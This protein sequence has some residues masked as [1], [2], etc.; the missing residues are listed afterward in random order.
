MHRQGGHTRHCKRHNKGFKLFK[1]LKPFGGKYMS[2]ELKPG[3]LN[4][5]GNGAQVKKNTNT[6]KSGWFLGLN[7]SE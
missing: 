4:C 5:W 6:A 7:T 3:G 1:G 2:P